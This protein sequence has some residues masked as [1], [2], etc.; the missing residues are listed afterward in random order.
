MTHRRDH[1]EVLGIGREAPPEEIKRAYRRI[2]LE[3]HPDRK[4]GDA[5]AEARFKEASHSYSILSDPDKRRRYDAHGHAGLG[6]A[7]GATYTAG[8]FAD[9]F[10]DLFSD[11]FG[12]QG[13][14]R[15]GAHGG[16]EPGEDL[17]YRLTLTLEEAARGFDRSITFSRME[18]CGRCLGDGAEPGHA[19][20]PCR[21]CG[22]RGEVR[23]QQAFFAMARTCPHCRG[24]GRMVDHPCMGCKGEGRVRKDRTLTVTV[25]PGVRD[26]TRLRLRG[27][28]DA[29][30]GRGH[31]GDLFVVTEV[32]EH[33]I[34]SR[35]GDNLLCDLPVRLEDAVLGAEVAIP[36]L[37]GSSAFKIPEGTQPGQVFHL[38]G[39][40]MPR[41][42][43]AGRGDLY[44][45]VLVEIPARFSRKQ[46]DALRAL[47]GGLGD[48]AYP[49]VR[50]FA[51]QMEK[52]RGK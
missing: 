46:K 47:A 1:Y 16:G 8:G 52:S 35:D 31:R 10:S 28:G 38:R 5:A 6:G 27:E 29:G 33:A 18:E 15:G 24:R 49:R 2:A 42:Q 9:V 37:E 26:G 13:G 19:P 30:H 32:E 21:T 11:I 41:L 22:G 43:G 7:S 14:P 40:G 50:E 4:P 25:P 20:V 51:R 3:C 45:R 36:A 12:P 17:R 23:F 44:L 48:G 39:R 34:F